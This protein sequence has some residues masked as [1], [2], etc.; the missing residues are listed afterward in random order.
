VLHY[1]SM[2]I[3]PFPISTPSSH[4]FQLHNKPPVNSYIS[5]QLQDFLYQFLLRFMPTYSQ[6]S[7]LQALTPTPP[8]TFL[9]ASSSIIMSARTNRLVHSSARMDFQVRM[10]DLNDIDGR[11]DWVDCPPTTPSPKRRKDTVKVRPLSVPG[12]FTVKMRVKVLASM[13]PRGDRA[14]EKKK[15]RYGRSSGSGRSAGSRQPS[16]GSQSFAS[17][18]A[19]GSHHSLRSRQA[20]PRSH[21]SLESHHVYGSQRSSRSRHVSEGR[22]SSGRSSRKHKDEA[23]CISC[24]VYVRRDLSRRSLHLKIRLLSGR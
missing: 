12:W 8:S 11:G 16:E 7:K 2:Y 24:V 15:S 1:H 19:P 14:P 18:H 23:G 10:E 3:Y 4:I 5:N 9:K 20:P 22:H 13:Y 6:L 21:E 17:R